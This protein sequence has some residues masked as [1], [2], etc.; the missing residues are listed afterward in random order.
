MENDVNWIV[1]NS[2]PPILTQ[3][4]LL[5]KAFETEEIIV[6]NNTLNDKKVVELF[7][8]YLKSYYFILKYKRS[9]IL[10]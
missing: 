7:E 2:F 1:Q 8:S 9:K 3:K 4:V 5:Q 6:A 10:F